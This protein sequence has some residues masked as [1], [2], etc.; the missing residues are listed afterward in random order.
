MVLILTAA[1]S[2]ELAAM[3]EAIYFESRGEPKACQYYVAG[4]IK[5]RMLNE[6]FPDTIQ[7][8]VEQPYQ[9]SYKSL[10]DLTMY[11]GEAKAK[12]RRIAK[13][14]LSSSHSPVFEN[15]LYFHTKNIEPHWSSSMTEVLECGNHIFYTED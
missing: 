14:V 4:V 10:D 3:T 6:R 2:V 7:D 1:F 8:V 12:A 5:N 15:I 9:F 13:S 11:N